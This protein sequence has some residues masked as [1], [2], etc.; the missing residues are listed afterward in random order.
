[1]EDLYVEGRIELQP[2]IISYNT[3]L[4][5]FA[6]TSY[7][8]RTA[9]RKAEELLERMGSMYSDDSALVGKRTKRRRS[10]RPNDISY[11]TV[12]NCWARLRDALSAHRA[13]AIINHIEEKF[14]VGSATF[15]PDVQ[16]Y[17]TVLA[18]WARSPISNANDKNRNSNSAVDRT[19]KLLNQMEIAYQRGTNTVARPNT[20]RYN[21]LSNAMAQ[22]S[23][24][25]QLAA[26]R[27]LEILHKMK[28]LDSQD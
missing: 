5:I 10:C 22:A 9:A 19:M 11:S 20:F 21:I 15:Q 12:L 24:Y 23:Q 8:D 4:D 6:Q 13:E 25:D 28:K 16:A 18:A 2:D 1:M 3:V 7:T 27:A 26:N 14:K 17:N